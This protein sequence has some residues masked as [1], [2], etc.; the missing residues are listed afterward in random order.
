MLI[1][2]LVLAILGILLII[3]NH[4]HPS[5]NYPQTVAFLGYLLVIVGLVLFLWAIIA[6]FRA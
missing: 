4:Y 1:T 3:F 2:G 6:Y 5:K